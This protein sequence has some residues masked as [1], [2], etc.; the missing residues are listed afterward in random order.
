MLNDDRPPSSQARRR[1]PPP[2]P[3]CEHKDDSASSPKPSAPQSPA[4]PS[5][6]PP[7]VPPKESTR[8][9]SSKKPSTAR[10][11][12]FFEG[13]VINNNGG[14]MINTVE[15]S[16]TINESQYNRYESFYNAGGSSSLHGIHS[17]EDANPRAF[18]TDKRNVSYGGVNRYAQGG[19]SYMNVG[20][21]P[22]DPYPDGLNAILEENKY[23]RR[24]NE[25]AKD[26]YESLCK[27]K[28]YVEN[29]VRY[30]EGE[31]ER[32]KAMLS[33]QKKVDEREIEQ[34]Q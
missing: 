6:A 18:A 22:Y 9:Q 17:N 26:A 20:E 21:V 11:I 28:D 7:S 31:I 24:A 5:S 10:G 4:P 33:Q 13:A 27:D 16:S 19:F 1:H 2:P 29:R 3:R 32:L 30:L 12:S 25:R 23:L 34:E 8:P 15:N 14:N